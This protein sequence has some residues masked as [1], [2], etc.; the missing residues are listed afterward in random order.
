MEI[1]IEGVAM[2]G[3]PGALLLD[4][5]QAARLLGVCERTVDNLRADGKLRA[6]RVRNR[7]LFDPGDLAHFIEGQ[8]EGAALS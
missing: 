6:V 8:K 5:P 2:P 3:Q 4:K 1:G 7:V